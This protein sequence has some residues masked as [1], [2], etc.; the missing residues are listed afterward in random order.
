MTNG[1]ESQSEQVH[2]NLLDN[3]LDFLLSSAEAVYRDG[4]LRS[5]KEA[6]LHLAN[7]I[8]LVL[9]ARLVREHWSLIFSNINHASIEELG[10]ADFISVDYPTAIKRLEQ[11]AGVTID[12][13]TLSHIGSLRKL[14]NQIT[15]FIAPLESTQMKSVV[16]KSMTFCLE[17]CEQ[18]GMVTPEVTGKIG[19]IQVNLTEFQ[20]FVDA[21]MRSISKEWKYGLILECPECWQEALVI[22]GGEVECKYCK[23]TFDPHELASSRSEGSLED[24][25]ECWE[26]QTFA[27]I[28]YNNDSGGWM[29]FSCGVGGEHYDHCMRCYRM[30]DFRGSED[31]KV[32]RSC[33]S[34]WADRE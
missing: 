19:E 24:C 23:R 31:F 9:K 17:F 4:G 3:A 7:G 10:K 16:A 11:F 22:D 21:R 13:S 15:H 27:F 33:W 26:E 34:D 29:C 25:P 5:Q 8:E 6:V 30:E 32:C 28:L 18:Q 12:K 14:R 20:E 1:T 2:P